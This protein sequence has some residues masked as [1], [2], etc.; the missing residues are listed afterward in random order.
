MPYK[1]VYPRKGL[2][3]L[4][5]LFVGATLGIIYAFTSEHLAG[6]VNHP[7]DL[8]EQAGTSFVVSVPDLSPPNNAGGSFG[9]WHRGGLFRG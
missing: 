9:P 5:G 3:L 2:N 1:P 8:A 7:E 6:T 4:L